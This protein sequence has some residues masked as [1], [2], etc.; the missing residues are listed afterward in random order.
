MMN[1]SK[2]N[3]KLKGKQDKD[4]KGPKEYG[5]RRIYKVSFKYLSAPLICI[6]IELSYHL[7]KH[8][9]FITYLF[10]ATFS[11]IYT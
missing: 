2:I 8:G 10:F 9:T 3:N 5:R 6:H 7:C 4:N 1:A 11:Q